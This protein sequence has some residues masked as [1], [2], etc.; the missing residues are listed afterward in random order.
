MD[1]DGKNNFIDA[2]DLERFNTR[3]VNA[4]TKEEMIAEI[5]EHSQAVQVRTSRVWKKEELE[6]LGIEV[7]DVKW[8]EI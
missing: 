5:L 6:R 3:W 1:D 2:G 4:R 8:E 7:V